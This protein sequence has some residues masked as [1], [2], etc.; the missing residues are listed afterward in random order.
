MGRPKKARTE[1]PVERP[2]DTTQQAP[3]RVVIKLD[4]KGA[5]DWDNTT[6]ENKDRLIAA[7]E[8]DPDAAKT[9]GLAASENM[10]T[11][12]QIKPLLDIFSM[13]A[14]VAGQT[15]AV[16]KFKRPLHAQAA[17]AI[18]LT[19]DQKD[20]IAP[21]AARAYNQMMPDAAKKYTDLGI[22][23]SALCA[24]FTANFAVAFTIEASILAQAQAK[25]GNGQARFVPDQDQQREVSAP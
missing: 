24:A 8:K 6:Q 14:T 5:P 20:N 19:D 13:V 21:P 7:F 1:G 4:D 23:V 12:G 17:A 15:M 25:P 18:P 9:L 3:S 10:V 2:Q 16:K 11:P 22:A